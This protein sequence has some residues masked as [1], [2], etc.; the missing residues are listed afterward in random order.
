MVE[1]L[2][3]SMAEGEELE[4]IWRD[5]GVV[6][7]EMLRCSIVYEAGGILI[8]YKNVWTCCLFLR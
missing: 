1:L 5:I 3:I 4:G 6:K 7:M 8:L 2:I